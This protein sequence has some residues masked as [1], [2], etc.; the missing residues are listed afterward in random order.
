MFV[1]DNHYDV[2]GLVLLSCLFCINRCSS[3]VLVQALRKYHYLAAPRRDRAHF[4]VRYWCYVARVECRY[5]HFF[6]FRFSPFATAVF[7][8]PIYEVRRFGTLIDDS[9]SRAGGRSGFPRRR[10]SGGTLLT[11]QTQGGNQSL[12]VILMTSLALCIEGDDQFR[13]AL[14]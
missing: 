14:V 1:T 13:I 6:R 10:R 11:I 5:T 8:S 3:Q 9:S 7:N 2:F 12:I 4:C